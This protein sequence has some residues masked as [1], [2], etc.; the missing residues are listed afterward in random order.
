M[1]RAC[2]VIRPTTNDELA[3]ASVRTEQ[4]YRCY[5]EIRSFGPEFL[6][7]GQPFWN[8]KASSAVMKLSRSD[9]RSTS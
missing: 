6:G 5:T 2:V 1:Q 4:R 7:P 9:A 8:F 3:A